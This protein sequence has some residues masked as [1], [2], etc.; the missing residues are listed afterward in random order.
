[1]HPFFAD[2]LDLFHRQLTDLTA[3]ISGLP[4]AAL[5][6]QPGSETNSLCVQVVHVVGAGR[7]W[8]GD[9]ALG[10][11][12][13]RDRAAEFRAS[14]LNETVLKGRIAAFE[15]YLKD[16]V[17]RLKI[18]DLT[19]QHPAP[20]RDASYTVG[21]ALMHAL[22]HTAVHVGHSQITRQMWDQRQ[23]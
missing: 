20:G 2:Y 7:Y 4:Q 16:G 18:E 15:A 17:A 23:D 12:S 10:E 6:W 14:G 22:D 11:P 9:V 3:A 19:E 13:N 8:A 21:W 1:M 5:D